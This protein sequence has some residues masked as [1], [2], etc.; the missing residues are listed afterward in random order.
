M[1]S[2]GL[3][4]VCSVYEG[5]LMPSGVTQ[6]TSYTSQRPYPDSSVRSWRE[7]SL[8]VLSLTH[9]PNT[10]LFKSAAMDENCWYSTSYA[11]C[12]M[13]HKSSQRQ[14]K[15]ERLSSISPSP[16][17]PVQSVT[18][19]NLEVLPQKF[20]FNFILIC[21]N[22][23]KLLSNFNWRR[24]WQPTPVFLPGESHGRKSLV[25]YSPWGR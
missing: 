21:L 15:Y 10:F 3:P 9:T 6:R 25:G 5:V 17:F 16:R 20:Q 1:I 4:K 11:R 24:K 12:S 18:S 7:E 8:E 22:V 13:K 2:V 23:F 19:K 14:S